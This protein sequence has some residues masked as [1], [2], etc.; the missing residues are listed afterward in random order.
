MI[1]PSID[2]AMEYLKGNLQNFY[3]QS[4]VLKD[5]LMR[6]GSLINQ[7]T[8]KGDQQAIGHLILLQSQTKDTFNDQLALEQTLMPFAQYFNVNTT[9]GAFPIIIA[10]TAIG[11]AGMLYLHFEKLQ[12][13][14]KAL[15]LVAKGLLSPDQYTQS[16]S[17]GS[18]FGSGGLTGLTGNLSTI[19]IFGAIVYGLFVFG[20]LLTRSTK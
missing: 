13:Q 15:D 6:I 11:V 1:F 18:F 9:L 8:A 2:S 5:R 16:E 14:A 19:A 4:R 20:P 3:N 7:A 10:A 17:A 12:N